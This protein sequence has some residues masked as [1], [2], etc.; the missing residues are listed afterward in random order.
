MCCIYEDIEINSNALKITHFA[1]LV[2]SSDLPIAQAPKTAS[3]SFYFVSMA[4]QTLERNISEINVR[5]YHAKD[6]AIVRELFCQAM[7]E[8]V[9][10]G[11]Q[12]GLRNTKVLAYLALFFCLGYQYSIILAFTLLSLAFG[13]QAAS[14]Y[15]FYALYLK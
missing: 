10:I 15:F 13:V 6:Y 4:A 11:I 2:F 1:K 9:P 12:T 5:K 8:A 3:R 7:M 14:V